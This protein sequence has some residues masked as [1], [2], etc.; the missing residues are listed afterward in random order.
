MELQELL[1][2][3]IHNNLELNEVGASG[4]FFFADLAGCFL[5][6]SIILR[7]SSRLVIYHLREGPDLLTKTEPP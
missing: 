4:N 3:I 1:S 7:I 5:K 6:Y 2:H